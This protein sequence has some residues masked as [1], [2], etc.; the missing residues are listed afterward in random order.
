MTEEKIKLISESYLNQA[1]SGL[2]KENPK[3]DFKTQW[4]N[5]KDELEI[6]EFIKDTSAIANTPGLDG[7]IIIGY[8]EKT[9]TFQPAQFNQCGL[10]DSNELTGLIIKRVDRAYNITNYDIALNGNN[11][12]VIHIPPSFDKP[13]VIR[14]YKSRGGKEEEQRV[15]IR[16]G[17]STRIANKYDFDFISYDR[18]NNLP[19][20]LVHIST[21][22]VGYSFKHLGQ[23]HIEL[24]MNLTFENN[25]LRPVAIN[26]I[27]LEITINDKTENFKSYLNKQEQL[28]QHI[29]VSNF[30]IQPATIHNYPYLVFKSDKNFT[31]KDYREFYTSNGDIKA[32]KSTL[33][34]NTGRQLETN[35]V[36]F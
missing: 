23:E 21:S 20:Y 30:V 22:I 2:D 17:T 18:K 4:Y 10:L 14:K 3:L 31:D 34:I 16:N 13:H 1:I 24:T 9:K 15:F 8:K 25:G 35:V 19:E 28:N 7:F 11:L 12:S 6:N 26:E 29:K 33:K 36:I 32:I 5:L 27:L